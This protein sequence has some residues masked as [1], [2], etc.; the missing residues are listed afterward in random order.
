MDEV[1]VEG[2]TE[3]DIILLKSIVESHKMTVTDLAYVVH[4][5][6]LYDKL[7]QILAYI[8]E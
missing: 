3:D 1:I 7:T 5:R 4:V 8:K 2:L 6:G